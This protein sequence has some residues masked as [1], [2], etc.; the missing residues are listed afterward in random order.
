MEGNAGILKRA[1]DSRSGHHLDTFGPAPARLA[2]PHP[3]GMMGW[4]LDVAAKAEI[5]AILKQTVTDPIGSEF[6]A[7]LV[8]S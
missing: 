7:P 8:R 6:M 4:S 5:D 2:E 3:R 1:M